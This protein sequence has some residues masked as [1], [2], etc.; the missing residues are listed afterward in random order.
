M[1]LPSLGDTSTW[2]SRYNV[3]DRVE[4]RLEYYGNK[5]NR[6]LSFAAEKTHSTVSPI[7]HTISQSSVA[8]ALSAP[9][10]KKGLAEYPEEVCVPR[11]SR[12]T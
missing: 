10:K 1:P 8:A 6:S 9:R 3:T 4:A 7:A 5:V 2:E 12:R 11:P